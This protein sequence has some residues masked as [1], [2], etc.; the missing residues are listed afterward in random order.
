M[1]R[2]GQH[3]LILSGGIATGK[4][5]FATEVAK[6]IVGN[7]DKQIH[8]FQFHEGYSYENFVHGV[9][10]RTENQSLK[11]EKGG[12][13]VQ[14]IIELCQK[15]TNLEHVIIIDD[16]NRCNINTVLG[17]MLT[18]L[19]SSEVGNV[20]KT[21]KGDFKIPENLFIIATM[22]PM[23]GKESI[24]YAWFRRFTVIEMHADDCYFDLKDEYLKEYQ[25]Y[26]NYAG[27]IFRH[28]KMLFDLYF[29]DSD[30]QREKELCKL[31]QGLYIQYD[32]DKC[33]KD[34]IKALHNRLKYIVAPLLEEYVK[35]GVLTDEAK[36]DIVALKNLMGND[37]V[38]KE[39]K[40]G[41][42]AEAI[43]ELHK[44]MYS[45][46]KPFINC[47]RSNA[48][49][50]FVVH[51]SN[52]FYQI[53]RKGKN[54]KLCLCEAEKKASII[55]EEQ[56]KGVMNRMSESKESKSENSNQKLNPYGGSGTVKISQGAEDSVKYILLMGTGTNIFKN[57]KYEEDN[58]YSVTS[59]E[60]CVNKYK[61]TIPELMRMLNDF[62]KELEKD[63]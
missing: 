55:N 38:F 13:P 60:H 45:E 53:T 46:I 4:T 44:K 35:Q 23:I 5:F 28:V 9:Q 11:Y 6:K 22:N 15:D 42:R 1:M 25:D 19:E 48:Y 31:G 24:D 32:S 50:F 3:F 27:E 29:T 40:K 37:I 41:A 62:Y 8:F 12:Q 56:F 20:I 57:Q 43:V 58:Y 7:N 21:D 34:N 39:Y 47:D 51:S 17:D 10:I 14:E 33:F 36:L 54:D 52:K 2:I 49:F 61:E 30:R 59:E 18:A 26:L 63:E 16:L